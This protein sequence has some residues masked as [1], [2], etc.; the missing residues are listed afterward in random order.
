MNV[1]RLWL[2][3]F[4]RRPLEVPE[5]VDRLTMLGAPVDAVEP[6]HPGLEDI[7]V[8]LVE[9]VR[10]HPNADRLRLCTVND[11]SPV[12]KQVVC[13]A[14]NVVAGG[15]YPF[16]PVGATLPK[17]FRIE[18][19]KIRGE[20]SEGMLCSARELG[21]GED[22]DG[23]LELATTAAPG[24]RLLAV[25]AV[26]DDRLVVDVTPNRP[27]L[28]GHKGVAREL[29][30][31]FGIP[32]RLPELPGSPGPSSPA[33]RRTEADRVQVGGVTLGLDDPVGC[34]RLLGA[35][36]K[37]VRVAASPSWLADRLAAVGMRSINNVVDATNY[38]M[39]ELNQPMHAYDV[40][41]LQGPAVIARRARHGERMVTLD[42]TERL[43]TEDMT[44]IADESGAIGV[45]GVM[46]A[47]HVEVGPETRDVFLECA[48]FE[49]TRIRRTRRTLGLSTEASH[50]F[51]RGVDRW[52]GA[53]AL[54]R[55]I[56][57]IQATAGGS[58]ADFPAD[59][60]PQPSTPPRIFL[61]PARVAKVLGVEFPTSILEQY[62]VAIGAV[63]LAKPDDERLVVDVPGW[64]PDLVG[65]IDLIEEIAR[66][67]GYGR[68]PEALRPHR[69]TEL[70]DA[71]L[72]LAARRVREGLGALGLYE[73]QSFPLVPP[74]AEDSVAVVNP[75]SAEESAL[76]RRLLPGLVRQCRAN[77][78]GRVRDIRLFEIGTVFRAG[79]P[80]ERPQE[81]S[82]L[83]AVIS[84]SR[85]PGHW[86]DRGRELDF[87]LWDLKGLFQAAVSLALPGGTW[88][89]DGESLVGL[90]ASGAVRGRAE[91]LR[92]DGP[93]WAAPVYGF[94]LQ[95]SPDPTP[96]AQFRPL[97][98]TPA[99]E[100]DLATVLPPGRRAADV[101]GVVRRAAGGLLESVEVFDEYR[102]PGLPPGHRGVAFRLVLRA[103]ERTLRDAEVDA[104]VERVVAAL[105]K[106]LGVQ[107]RTS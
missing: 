75:L 97:P 86:T 25:L 90:D 2:E 48:C 19:R 36:V 106:E 65:E 81:T 80:G 40:A 76:R 35:V 18:R 104:V 1:S 38:V 70:P 43:L 101:A 103:S 67:H 34:P 4:L 31:S 54:R 107:L 12:L 91:R 50:R 51:E 49:P 95:L 42:G 41:R 94:E 30:A 33:P 105:E 93:P 57:I 7:V 68:F 46:G 61:R 22:Q 99:A 59:L 62:L 56:E 3:A 29:A 16:A 32:F 52:G 39:F 15:K 71:P 74:E 9:E 37:G 14:P 58:L 5:L 24:T 77:W 84:G 63:V 53:E 45:A 64:R 8:G 17:D 66:L 102:G 73:T 60:W 55:C 89:V 13:G 83:A 78:S 44:V 28:L 10:V 85:E 27:D 20:V 96:V 98:S 11:G 100:R 87:D 82:Q 6:L 21:L 88:Q 72:E 23:L 26:A 79:S 92:V 47:A 69:P